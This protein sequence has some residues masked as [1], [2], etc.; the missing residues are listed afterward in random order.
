[1]LFERKSLYQLA[2]FRDNL[3]GPRLSSRFRLDGCHSATNTNLRSVI[4]LAKNFVLAVELASTA[5]K[6]ASLNATPV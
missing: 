3:T 4:Q 1:M 6:M 2:F 5:E